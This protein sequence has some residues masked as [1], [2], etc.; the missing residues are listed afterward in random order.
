LA[1]VKYILSEDE[2]KFY[3]P[4]T[5]NLTVEKKP[6]GELLDQD[7]LCQQINSKYDNL[8]LVSI[9]LATYGH[10]LT[11]GFIEFNITDLN[12]MSLRN[13]RISCSDIMDNEMHPISFEP[14]VDSKDKTYLLFLKAIDTINGDAPTCW[15]KNDLSPN[16]M[17]LNGSPV[18]GNAIMQMQ[19]APVKYID[20]KSG[21]NIYENMN[22]LPRVYFAGSVE[23]EVDNNIILDSLENDLTTTYLN[24]DIQNINY[25]SFQQI[26]RVDGYD[27]GD[28]IVTIN[29]TTSAPRL[30]VLTDLYYPGWHAYIDGVET[31]MHQVNTLFRGVVVPEGTHVVKMKYEPRAFYVGQA[32]TIV[33]WAMLFLT[34][35]ILANKKRKCKS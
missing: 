16:K 5:V 15:I 30:L 29:A 22:A 4:K 21:L 9:L 18:E 25:N 28:D 3:S 27:I 32:I 10:D 34:M 12:G 19:Y 31:D 1:S 6:L 7:I 23:I 35:I 26:D 13:G 11:Q 33:S 2:I 8:E 20:T 24:E 17:T 14:I